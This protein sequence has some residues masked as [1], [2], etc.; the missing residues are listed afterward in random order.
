MGLCAVDKKM[1]R[2]LFA[3]VLQLVSVNPGSQE[4]RPVCGGHFPTPSCLQSG[5]QTHAQTPVAAEGRRNC[6]DRVAM[7]F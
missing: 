7:C 1:I 4:I 5:H 2:V 6:S 3:A